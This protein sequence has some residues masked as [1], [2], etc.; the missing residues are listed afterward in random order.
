M[1]SPHAAARIVNI[2]TSAAKAIPGV[3]AVYTAKDLSLK[4][5]E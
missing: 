4:G 3:V 2:D 1:T 5:M